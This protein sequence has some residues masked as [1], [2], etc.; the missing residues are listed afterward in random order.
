[1][2]GWIF[3]RSR[4]QHRHNEKIE[5][6]VAELNGG[7]RSIQAICEM[8]ANGLEANVIAVER[9]PN[10]FVV[11][12]GAPWKPTLQSLDRLALDSCFRKRDFAGKGSSFSAASDWLFVPICL[13]GRVVAALGLA[14]RFLRRRFD[15][16][17]DPVI[18]SVKGAMREA[19]ST[20]SST[21]P[22]Q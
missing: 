3:D 9:M 2:F 5:D 17:C 13:R 8:V 20:G 22:P 4:P 21:H 11:V 14:G 12:A 6:L 18:S 1:M 19:Y 16:E 15:P 7:S 10:D